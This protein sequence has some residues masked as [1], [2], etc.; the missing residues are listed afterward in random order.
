VIKARLTLRPIS[1]TDKID[2]FKA[3]RWSFMTHEELVETSLDSDF[4]AA[5]PMIL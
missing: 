3:I 2:V 5:R 4:E 1:E